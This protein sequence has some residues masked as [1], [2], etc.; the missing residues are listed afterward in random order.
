MAVEV[1]EDL[2]RAVTTKEKALSDG[3]TLSKK[4]AFKNVFKTE[5][6]TLLW[7]QCQGS[8]AK[9]YELSV[10]LGG[11]APTLRCSCPVK[12]PPCKHTLGFLVHFLEQAPKFKA[13][14]PPADLVEKRAKS[15]VR[16]EKRAE[17]SAKPKEANVAAQKKKSEAQRKAIDD[18]L[19]PLLL[20]AVKNG[21]GAI[22][23]KRAAKLIEQAR[24]LNDAYLP[25]AA[26]RLRRIAALAAPE[27]HDDDEDV[28]YQLRE[29]GDDLPDEERHRLMTR[30]VTRLWAMVR[31]GRKYLDEKLDEGESQDDADAVVEEL[32][33]RVWK[34]DE[35]KASG[36]A[37]QKLELLELAYER[38]DDH[39]RDERIEQSWLLDLGDGT[40]YVDRTFRPTDRM[41]KMKEGESYEKPLLIADAAIYPGFVNKRIRWEIGARKSRNVE[42]ADF[43]RIHERA[44]TLDAA[45][46]K[47]KE[48][49][50]NPLAPDD[51]VFLLRVK[52]VRKTA[53]GLA[54]VDAKGAKLSL[55]D[56]VLARYRSLG[57]LEMAAGAAQDASGA[58]KQPASMLVRLYVGLADE[59]IHGQ[60]L[61]LIVGTNHVRVGM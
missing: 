24:Q 13:A 32:L 27:K 12:P 60:P 42:V 43:D 53:R 8:G 33:G 11:D 23:K 36:H 54:L 26:E 10:D 45:L 49:I 61:A 35:L 31:K 28:Y 19:E 16:A 29:P 39:V 41:D 22:D 30:H 56:S 34:L 7:G 46:P 6:G 3:R 21:I 9:P 17:A 2:I 40:I 58:L 48:Q 47:F 55:A 18:L 25:G 52:D 44:V 51:A 57:N 15:A 4:G 38:Y 5:D 37:K 59:A 50:K 20:D 1:S 14:E